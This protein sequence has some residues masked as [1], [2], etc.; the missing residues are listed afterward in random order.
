MEGINPMQIFFEEHFLTFYI[1]A[2]L[3]EVNTCTMCAIDLEQK[4]VSC[5]KLLLLFIWQLQ[6]MNNEH[7]KKRAVS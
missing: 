3:R 1:C 5:V 6:A 7:N 4:R 2:L